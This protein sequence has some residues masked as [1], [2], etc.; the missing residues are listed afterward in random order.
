MTGRSLHLAALCVYP[1][2][3]VA[4]GVHGCCCAGGEGAGLADQQ[5]DTAPEAGLQQLMRN[6][7][8]LTQ[9][10]QQKQ[11]VSG[12]QPAPGWTLATCL[13]ANAFVAVM[14]NMQLENSSPLGSQRSALSGEIFLQQCKCILND[15]W[16]KGQGH[17]VRRRDI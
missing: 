15:A 16:G 10:Q 17:L 5:S 1:P 12:T 6:V 9:T 3:E 13:C 14:G 11:D 7:E 4:K 8:A 2:G